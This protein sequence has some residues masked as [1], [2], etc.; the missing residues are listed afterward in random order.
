MILRAAIPSV[1]F[2]VESTG[3]GFGF[4]WSS[5]VRVKSGQRSASSTTRVMVKILPAPGLDPETLCTTDHDLNH[6]GYAMDFI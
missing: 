6:Y 4:L 5:H 3:S 2:R 1:V